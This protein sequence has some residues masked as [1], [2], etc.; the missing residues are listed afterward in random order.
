M[1]IAPNPHARRA[2]HSVRMLHESSLTIDMKPFR[3][4]KLANAFFPSGKVTAKLEGAAAHGT[5]FVE[6]RLGG[7]WV[8]GTVE[9]SQLGVQFHANAMNK[10]L[11]GGQTSIT[12]PKG[13]IRKLRRE[14]G[15]LTGIVVVEH[16]Q[17]EFRFRCYGAKGVVAKYEAAAAASDA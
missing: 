7:L 15:F 4:R 14:F 13:A 3:I 17:G 8:G 11:H 5:K 6:N 1:S 16:D 9:L 10:A 12:I 2:G